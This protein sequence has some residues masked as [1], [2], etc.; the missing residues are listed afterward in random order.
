MGLRLG[1]LA[2]N[3]CAETTIG[4]IDFHDWARGSWVFFFSHQADFTPIC[5]TELGFTARYRDAFA[6]R[7]VKPIAL[8]IDTI[9]A[10]HNWIEDI[11]ETQDV[12][13]NFPI[14]ADNDLAV[15][16]KYELIH[17]AQSETQPIRAV[18]IIDPSLRVQLVMYYPM[19]VG[20]NLDEILRVIDA[21]QV[22]KANDVLTP[23]NWQHGEKTIIPPNIDNERALG[24]YE[25]VEIVK[26]YLRFTTR[27]KSP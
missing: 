23:C 5:T 3:F 20:R 27:K 22:S 10:H 24:L 18:F 15:S 11:N 25:K 8:S 19:N 14:V 26:D 12:A 1:D 2:P 13:L 7:N 17:A 9:E 21:L 16:L 6:L 4:K